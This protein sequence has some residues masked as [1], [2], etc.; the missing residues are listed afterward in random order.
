MMVGLTGMPGAGKSTAGEALESLG[1]HRIVMGDVIREETKRRGL[2]ADQENTGKVMRELREE[3]G[4]AAVAEL[5]LKKILASSERFVVI[6]GIRSVAEVEAFRKAGNLLLIAIQASRQR[7]FQLLRE[8]GR[9]DDP[10]QWDTFIARDERELGIGLG[11]VIAL[12][13]EVV[14]NERSTPEDLRRTVV[15]IVMRWRQSLD[16]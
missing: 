11:N 8:R 2:Q 9:S 16:R 7:R 3:F 12:A 5:C 4:E 15:A 6:D 14:L 13:D 1:A 10:L